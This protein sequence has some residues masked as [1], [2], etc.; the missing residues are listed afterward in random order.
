M[1]DVVE[2]LA[3]AFAV[4]MLFSVIFGFLAYTRYLRYK[5]T[6]AL[7]ERGLLRPARRSGRG[8]IS[9][10]LRWGIVIFITGIG[11][12]I[13]LLILDTEAVIAGLI[14]MFFGLSLIVVHFVSRG[15]EEEDVA[16]T[17][18]SDNDPIPPHKM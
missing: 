16:E 2:V 15:E 5:E 14:S 17:A 3:P 18:V 7:A 8:R 6:I 12:S 11:L 4:C 9:L 13:G 1:T 10:T